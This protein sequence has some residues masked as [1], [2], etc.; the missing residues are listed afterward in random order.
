MDKIS[1]W[2]QCYI[3]RSKFRAQVNPLQKLRWLRNSKIIDKS[4]L[5][6]YIQT[7]NPGIKN[8]RRSGSEGIRHIC[9]Q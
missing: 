7:E 9:Y 2:R 3:R 4:Y 1:L 5:H 8:N 6:T